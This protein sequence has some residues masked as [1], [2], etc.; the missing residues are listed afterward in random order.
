ME[1]RI[2]KGT[3]GIQGDSIVQDQILFIPGKE[4][5]HN[6]VIIVE[7]I[8]ADLTSNSGTFKKGDR[9]GFFY[10]E[11]KETDTSEDID[12]D[13]KLECPQPKSDLFEY[14]YVQNS[15]DN[16]YVKYWKAKFIEGEKN[17]EEAIS[18]QKKEITFPGT[19]YVD[20]NGDLIELKETKVDN[21]DIGDIS[22]LLGLF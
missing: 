20:Q 6:T 11:I 19:K 2:I 21:T 3:A 18:I 9:P 7:D 4:P 17:Y 13:V 16:D 10:W 14:P 1:S 5:S 15:S 22:N 12:I 8:W